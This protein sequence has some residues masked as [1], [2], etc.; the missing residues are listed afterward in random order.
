MVGTYDRRLDLFHPDLQD[1][2]L[3]P[4]ACIYTRGD[5]WRVS[6]VVATCRSDTVRRPFATWENPSSFAWLDTVSSRRLLAE[7]AT[8]IRHRLSALT[9]QE[10]GRKRLGS[11]TFAVQ[12]PTVRKYFGWKGFLCQRQCP[13]HKREYTIKPLLVAVSFLSLE[14]E[15]EVNSSAA[16][17]RAQHIAALCVG[18][19][20]YQSRD[21]TCGD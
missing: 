9:T 7:S 5:S 13:H 3:V 18:F 10:K 14:R 19:M 21:C 11:G 20:W 6:G 2:M 4:Q 15:A 1:Y 16:W 8:P 17:M 12:S